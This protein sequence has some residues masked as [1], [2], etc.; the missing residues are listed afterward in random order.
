MKPYNGETEDPM[1]NDRSLSTPRERPAPRQS[2]MPPAG[3]GEV[4]R[5][6]VDHAQVIA[7]DALAIAKLEARRSVDRAKDRVKDAAPRIAFGATAGVAALVGVVLLLIAIFIGLGDAV[8]SVGWR[9]AIFGIFFL[10]VAVI[11]AI[12]AGSHEKRREAAPRRGFEEMPRRGAEETSRRQLADAP[13]RGLAEGAPV[14]AT[15][16]TSSLPAARH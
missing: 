16:D 7:R 3:L 8:P 10:V 5:D 2:E 15:R 14:A 9:L 12:F 11:A 4:A 1:N 6:V 13:R